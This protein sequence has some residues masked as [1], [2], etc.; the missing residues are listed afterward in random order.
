MPVYAVFRRTLAVV[1][2]RR[3]GGTVA[4]DH[5][6]LVPTGRGGPGSAPERCAESRER[7]PSGTQSCGRPA[8]TA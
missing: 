7:R 4:P 3:C 5:D 1:V 8:V 6:A 2:T